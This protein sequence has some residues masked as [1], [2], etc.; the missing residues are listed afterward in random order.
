MLGVKK[1]KVCLESV[2]KEKYDRL[3]ASEKRILMELLAG[4]YVAIEHVGSTSVPNLIAKPIIDIAVGTINFDNINEIISIME[5]EY[6]YLSDRGEEKRKI[7]VKYD[8]EYITH[9]IHIEEYGKQSWI[10]HI[11]FRNKLLESEQLRND[12]VKLKNS[13][14]AKYKDDR[15]KYTAG[16]ASFIQKVLHGQM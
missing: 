4:Y 13:L 9:H 1:Q 7:F 8:G 11:E 16:K 2:D 5:K 3:F 14:K 12:Y 15:D 10:N 6:V